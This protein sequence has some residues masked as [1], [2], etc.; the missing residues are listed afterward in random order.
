MVPREKWS[1]QIELEMIDGE[2]N[3]G[4][5]FSGLAHFFSKKNW[6]CN[7]VVGVRGNFA[8]LLGNDYLSSGTERLFLLKKQWKFVPSPVARVLGRSLET[9]KG[10]RKRG[11]RCHERGPDFLSVLRSKMRFRRKHE[12][13]VFIGENT[14]GGENRGD[15]RWSIGDHLQMITSKMGLLFKTHRE[16]KKDIGDQVIITVSLNI[17][18]K[19]DAF[20]KKL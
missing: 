16:G 2:R 15:H 18:L 11:I 17:F 10:A 20:L 13:C 9:E 5:R 3:K 12:A 7:F 14:Q 4:S 19:E 6:V 8:R 1:D